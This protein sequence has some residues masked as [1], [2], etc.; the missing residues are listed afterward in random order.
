[1]YTNPKLLVLKD[2]TY[3]YKLVGL[4]SVQPVGNTEG[5]RSVCLV[6]LT[7]HFGKTGVDVILKIHSFQTLWTK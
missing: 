1:M 6:E 2:A 7:Q 3:L 4:L 5:I